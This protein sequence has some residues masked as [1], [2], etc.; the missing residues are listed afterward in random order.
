MVVQ[1][2]R[3][4]TFTAGRGGEHRFDPWWENQ[5]LAW[6]D[7][8]L[9]RKKEMELG[10]EPVSVIHCMQQTTPEGNGL[11]QGFL[12]SHQSVGQQCGLGSVHWFVC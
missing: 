5:D 9:E 2:L 11:K 12:I 6:C 10:S 1:W 8:K 3:L 4:Q 7:Q